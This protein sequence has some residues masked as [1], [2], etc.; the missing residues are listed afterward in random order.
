MPYC[1]R[2]GAENLGDNPFCTNC[3]AR[4]QLDNTSY[5]G[6][7]CPYC[8][9]PIK[10]NE[11]IA[12][13]PECRMPHHQECWEENNG[14][15]SWGCE[16]KAATVER[17]G[18]SEQIYR[19]TIRSERARE[20]LVVGIKR[21]G[22][23][24]GLVILILLMI[25][26]VPMLIPML[27]NKISTK[28]LT[29]L[30]LGTIVYDSDSL[31]EFRSGGKY[32]HG[33]G[34]GSS[35][36]SKTKPV[37]WIIVAKNHPGYPANS[38]TLLSKGIIAQYPFDSSEQYKE[39]M[40]NFDATYVNPRVYKETGDM[41]RDMQERVW[42]LIGKKEDRNNARRAAFEA[43]YSNHWGNKGSDDTPVAIRAWLNNDF[44]N[45]FS[46]E[47]KDAILTTTLINATR[48]GNLYVT[49]DKIFL[50]SQTEL[51]NSPKGTY[52]I[53]IKWEHSTTPAAPGKMVYWTRSPRAK[54]SVS[55]RTI[56]TSESHGYMGYGNVDSN[57]GVRP[58][59]NI[60]SDIQVKNG[61]IIW[62]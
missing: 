3:G 16:G 6:K 38:V 39:L 44:Y 58:V 37:E 36:L 19:E 14:C 47:F 50:P 24:V 32:T 23:P 57:N 1:G 56:N 61:K 20:W 7:I 10:P 26:I 17:T 22:L 60:K 9:M 15:T 13:C 21:Y 59:L 40:E 51:G 46:P 45:H 25:M 33:D 41:H 53:G 12:I 30:P 42:I 27:I 49:E 29:D 4:I 11:G 31:W 35:Y 55:I 8:Q 48:T 62:E 28:P 34:T 5:V 52:S 54:S 2:C 43:C 18:G